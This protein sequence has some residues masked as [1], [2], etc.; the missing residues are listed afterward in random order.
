MTPEVLQRHAWSGTPKDL[1]ELFLLRKRGRDAVCTLTTHQFGWELRLL[2]AGELVQSQ[3]CRTQEDVFSTGEMWKQ[4][5]TA[6][7]WT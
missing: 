7:G 1:G 3:V 4:A 2:V 5:M 6:K